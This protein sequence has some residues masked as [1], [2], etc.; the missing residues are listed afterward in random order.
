MRLARQASEA[1]LLLA[2]ESSIFDFFAVKS[3]TSSS[4]FSLLTCAGGR[5]DVHEGRV[6]VSL[7]HGRVDLLLRRGV[8]EEVDG[9]RRRHAHQV[10]PQAAKQPSA[11]LRLH[12]VSEM[13]GH[14][15]DSE[16]MCILEASENA[17]DGFAP[18]GS[19]GGRGRGQR[20]AVSVAE[21]VGSAP[22]VRTA[23]GRLRCRMRRR[24][25]Y[26]SRLRRRLR[27][28][29][30]DGAAR[31]RR[32]RPRTLRGDVRHGLRHP[33]RLGWVVEARV[34]RLEARFDDLQRAGDDGAG[35][36]AHPGI[37]IRVGV[38]VIFR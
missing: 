24:V 18:S 25:A 19:T 30:F 11:A 20:P 9:S 16:K 1:I 34:R 38:V 37:H 2:L 28:C 12:D 32:A 31:R 5:D 22:S 26:S 35:R 7:G 14:L 33:D 23:R 36:A 17:T 3:D 21:P 13:R 29:L 6:P 4:S 15:R 8:G 27:P 10:G